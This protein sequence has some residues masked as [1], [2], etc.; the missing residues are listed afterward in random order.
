VEKALVIILVAVIMA[1]LFFAGTLLLITP[2]YRATVS[3]YV[4]NSSFSFDLSASPSPHQKSAHRTTW[5]TPM[6]SS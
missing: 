2:P 1:S 5:S 6:S 3:M 4:N